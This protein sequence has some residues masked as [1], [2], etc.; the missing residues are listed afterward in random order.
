MSEPRCV[1]CDDR[2]A[3]S[4]IF[5]RPCGNAFDRSRAA[6]DGTTHALIEWAAQAAR[7]HERNRTRRVYGA[8]H[9]R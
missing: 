7:K 6:D 3:V 4:L 5:C 9:G 2:K 8:A 1:I